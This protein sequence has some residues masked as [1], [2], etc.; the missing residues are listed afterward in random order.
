MRTWVRGLKSAAFTFFPTA[1]L[2]RPVV[3][4]KKF[5]VRTSANPRTTLTANG[6]QFIAVLIIEMLYQVR[7]YL[8]S[9]VT[10]EFS[11]LIVPGEI[12]AE[13]ISIMKSALLAF[14]LMKL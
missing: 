5:I 1:A 14:G 3:A 13:E 7:H 4:G 6:F 11:G 2:I 10:Y 9:A 12:R 8:E